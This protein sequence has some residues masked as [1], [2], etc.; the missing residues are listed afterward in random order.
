MQRVENWV[1]VTIGDLAQS[2]EKFEFNIDLSSL[3]CLP[4]LFLNSTLMIVLVL[5]PVFRGLEHFFT[6]PATF[7]PALTFAWFILDSSPFLT[8]SCIISRD[9]LGFQYSLQANWHPHYPPTP[10]LLRSE[11]NFASFSAFV[12]SVSIMWLSTIRPNV[13][14]CK[15][16]LHHKWQGLII[17]SVLSLTLLLLSSLIL[18]GARIRFPLSSRVK[19]V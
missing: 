12:T 16:F 6:F 7:H 3:G 2:S 9:K 8:S 4:C 10:L 11:F 1:H 17:L 19:S 15:T 14:L 18:S 13:S 5:L